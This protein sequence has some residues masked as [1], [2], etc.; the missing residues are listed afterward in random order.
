MMEVRV[1]VVTVEE[2][3]ARKII[4]GHPWVY[5]NEV[6]RRPEDL[7][8][9]DLVL[10]RDP[11]G[12]VLATGY[13]HKHSLIQI[14]VLT[15][16]DEP[17]DE[18][19]VR[20]RLAAA[21]ARREAC[22]PGLRSYRLVYGECD[23]LPGLVVDRYEDVLVVEMNTQGIFLFQDAIV[24]GLVAL[25]GPRAIVLHNASSALAYEQLAPHTELLHGTLEGPV[26]IDEYGVKC[27]VD[28]LQGQ[29]TGFFL[30]QR[31]NRRRLREYCP[32]RAVWDIFAYSG[33]WGLHALAAGACRVTFVDS[34]G[35]ACDLVR[36]NLRLNGWLDR[37]E[38]VQASA[39][40]HL[41]DLPRNSVEVL[42]LDP[43][44]F[45]KTKK[46]LPAALKAYVDINR[47]G[48]RVIGEGGVL[49]SS[50][51]SFHVG[52]EL[53]AEV[54]TRAVFQSRQRAELLFVGGQAPDHPV[55]LEFPESRYLDTLFLR[56]LPYHP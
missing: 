53:F 36:E 13:Y 22:C 55:H 50:S 37:A 34:S 21:L 28:P 12:R 29:K 4:A 25:L 30:D 18:D 43:P 35:P 1:K 2:R 42:V 40:D 45:A 31:E 44:A 32:G 17:V 23:G 26:V 33:A 5:A 16:R 10:V 7:D 47:E 19:L 9:V 27:L 54:M 46:D 51:C 11:D 38:V 14:R 20:R 39:F 52:A 6:V 49:A 41:R 15:R 24:E 8:D 3:A 56:K 48:L